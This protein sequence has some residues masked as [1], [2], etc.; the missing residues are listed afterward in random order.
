VNRFWGRWFAQISC[1]AIDLKLLAGLNEGACETFFRPD[2]ALAWGPSGL[3][4]GMVYAQQAPSPDLGGSGDGE[5]LP[6][7][8]KLW[9]ERLALLQ[10][11]PQG[12][13]VF[14]ADHLRQ[15]LQFPL[16]VR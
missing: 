1:I 16:V 14:G 13:P 7:S 11:L 15:L 2:L 10:A 9:P 8:E 6:G 3:F 5:A 4:A 12:R